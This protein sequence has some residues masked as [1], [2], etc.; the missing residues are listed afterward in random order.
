MTPTKK[1]IQYV[2]ANL[3]R[4]RESGREYTTLTRIKDTAKRVSAFRDLKNLQAR[5]RIILNL[6]ELKAECTLV[7]STVM[8]N[9]TIGDELK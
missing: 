9:I 4:Q 8:L 3:Q 2:I 6:P 7:G 1:Q 5:I